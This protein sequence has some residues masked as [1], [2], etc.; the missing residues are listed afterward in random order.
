MVPVAPPMSIDV[1]RVSL[2]LV[3]AAALGAGGCQPT[4]TGV[5]RARMGYSAAHGLRVVEV[6]EGPSRSAGLHVGDRV[7]SIDGEDV[8]AIVHHHVGD[9]IVRVDGDSEP[10]TADVRV[11]IDEKLRGQVGSRVTIRVMRDGVE[12]ELSIERVPPEQQR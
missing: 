2:G 8:Y 11:R 3:L 1:A 4:W 9:G 12:H 10:S 7:M 6:P 5:I